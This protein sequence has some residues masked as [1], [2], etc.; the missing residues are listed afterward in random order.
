MTWM[1]L[2]TPMTQD[3]HWVTTSAFMAKMDIL[4]AD[5]ELFFLH[6]FSSLVY[7]RSAI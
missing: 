2:G 4:V 5:N 3:L 6:G 1:I 7:P